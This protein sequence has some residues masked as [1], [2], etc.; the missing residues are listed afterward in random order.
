MAIQVVATKASSH[1]YSQETIDAA[2]R[3]SFGVNGVDK[4]VHMSMTPP[5]DFPNGP[6]QLYGVRVWTDDDEW[7][8]R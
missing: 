2:V 8:V 6:D 5:E 4:D 3:A 1:F 7:S